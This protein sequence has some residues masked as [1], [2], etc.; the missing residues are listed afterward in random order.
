[1]TNPQLPE[2][3]SQPTLSCC[4]CQQDSVPAPNEV[5]RTSS[6]DPF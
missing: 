6:A 4:H 1:M 5:D 3:S 2:E